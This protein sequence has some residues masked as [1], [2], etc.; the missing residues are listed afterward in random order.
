[1]EAVGMEKCIVLVMGVDGW[2]GWA[3]R[4]ERCG[5]LL[6]KGVYVRPAG[7]NGSGSGSGRKRSEDWLAGL[8]N[9]WMMLDVEYAGDGD[10]YIFFCEKRHGHACGDHT[11]LRR[12]GT[13]S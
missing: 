4:L 7:K 11:C 13:C 5:G 1:M 3:V 6:V 12:L 2:E 8:V 9:E 10:T